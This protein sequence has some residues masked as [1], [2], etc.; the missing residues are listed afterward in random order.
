M[1]LKNRP[2]SLELAHRL[3]SVI[4]L[5]KSSAL[6]LDRKQTKVF[7][8]AEASLKQSLASL[9]QLAALQVVEASQQLESASQWV[10]LAE[11][12]KALAAKAYAQM[13][14]SVKAGFNSDHELKDSQAFWD[15]AQ[16]QWGRAVLQRSA[17]QVLL[18]YRLGLLTP[19]NMAVLQAAA[20][21][22][23]STY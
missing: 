8:A 5:R 13:N 18:L 22:V 12:D 21:A 17:A 16:A 7:E 9:R 6:I 19:E 20:G 4:Q 14:V 23:A 1:A 2:D 3:E 15:D 10:Q 11:A